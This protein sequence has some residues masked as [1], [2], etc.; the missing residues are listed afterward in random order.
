M[1]F[2]RGLKKKRKTVVLQLEFVSEIYIGKLSVR[3]KALIE[4]AT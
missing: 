4:S 1:A 2:V 3:P